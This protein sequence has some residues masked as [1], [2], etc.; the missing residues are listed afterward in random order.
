MNSKLY[1]DIDGVL[2][3][4]KTTAAADGAEDFIKFITDHFECYWLTT[5]CKGNAL[6]AI[7]YL[8]NH[9][10]ADILKKLEKV[11]VTNWNT[12]KT[13]AINFQEKFIWIDD[14]AFDYERAIL[15]EKGLISSLV[16]VD[17]ERKKELF[18]LIERL[19]LL[20]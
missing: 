13:E 10:P 2:L 17:L 5:H 8:S 19:K 15:S 18:N 3:T 6:T 11:E 9:F 14:F 20:Q 1:I 4:R 12:S 7:N 16:I